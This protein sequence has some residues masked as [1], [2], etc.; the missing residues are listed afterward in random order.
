M[1]RKINNAHRYLILRNSDRRYVGSTDD[2]GERIP[3]GHQRVDT[4]GEDGLGAVNGLKGIPDFLEWSG[5]K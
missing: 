2:L 4:I 3:P 1:M 5:H